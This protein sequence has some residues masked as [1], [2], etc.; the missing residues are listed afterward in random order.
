MRDNVLKDRDSDAKLSLN[1]I[2]LTFF[3]VY[4]GEIEKLASPKAQNI[5]MELK[6][7]DCLIPNIFATDPPIKAPNITPKVSDI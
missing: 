1:E 4:L 2:T 5:M 3:G 7:N 6:I